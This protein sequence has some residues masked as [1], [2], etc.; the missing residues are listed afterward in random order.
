MPH[1]TEQAEP[2]EKTCEPDFARDIS[3]LQ[4]NVNGSLLLI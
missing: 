1:D 3:A 2:D 4:R